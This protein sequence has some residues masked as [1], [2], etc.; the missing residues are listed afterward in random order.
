MNLLIE[1]VKNSPQLLR[2][3]L[4][5]E[6]LWPMSKDEREKSRKGYYDNTLTVTIAELRRV[7]GEEHIETVAGYGYR[8]VTPVNETDGRRSTQP[9]MF[10]TPASEWDPPVGA[11]KA[12]SPFY[13]SRAAD[14]ELQATI[15]RRDSFV[16]VK[17]ARQ[18]GKTSLLARGLQW[19]RE[20]GALVMITDFQSL[21]AG[22]FADMEKLLLTLR[23][24]IARE[25]DLEATQEQKWRKSLPPGS[26]FQSY[27][28]EV[29]ES[30]DAPLVW[31]IDEVDKLFGHSYASDVFGLFRSFHSLRALKPAGP[32]RQFTMVLAYAAEVNVFI[33][34]L[35]QSP[36]NI[37]TRLALEDFTLE[38][39]AELN[40]RYG[41]P[42]ND[43]EL[44]RYQDL[45]GGHP[46]LVHFGIYWMASHK[47]SLATL[48]V[49][50]GRDEGPFGDHLRR[51]QAFL[52]KDP[53][54]CEA[55]RAVL[56]GQ[57]R[58]TSQDFYR[59]RAAGVLSG[60]SA[61]KAALRSELYAAYLRKR[62][63]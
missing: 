59:L 11:L 49:Q 36:F 7:I 21:G 37:G 23:D 60:D 8:F 17:G 2:K 41:S 20:T 25:L 34:D 47:T 44:A 33:S 57:G 19:A 3:E 62:L 6:T 15:N 63:L 55:V 14:C 22:A 24:L 42:L 26:N 4:L 9:E 58:L 54:L 16:L 46:Y 45:V 39:A 52:E 10:T 29:L 40:R 56:E 50:A 53:A 32:W 12:D 48:E 1:L 61:E 51:M 5:I 28:Q 31:A 27:L 38:Q 18:V 43:E 35:N 13:V 30:L